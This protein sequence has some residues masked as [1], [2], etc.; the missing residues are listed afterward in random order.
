MGPYL[1]STPRNWFFPLIGPRKSERE[2]PEEEVAA[3]L[4][5]RDLSERPRTMPENQEVV[6]AEEVDDAVETEDADR[7]RS[8]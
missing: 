6:V 7:D 1:K 4:V 5:P 2:P 8:M 3:I